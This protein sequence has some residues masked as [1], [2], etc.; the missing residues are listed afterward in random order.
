LPERE[1]L[2]ESRVVFAAVTVMVVGVRLPTGI[3]VGVFAAVTASTAD[4]V[5]QNN[6]AQVTSATANNYSSEPFSHLWQFIML[7]FHE[8]Q[9][10]E[11]YPC[12]GKLT[13]LKYRSQR[14]GDLFHQRALH[15]IS[16]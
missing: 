9:R 8:R 12:G 16:L 6:N 15:A 11:V 3:V 4:V 14:I 10:E 7:A 2:V 5:L 13:G 1:E